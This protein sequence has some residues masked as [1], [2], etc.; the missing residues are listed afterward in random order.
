MGY[1]STFEKPSGTS[2]IAEKPSCERTDLLLGVPLHGVESEAPIA[3]NF[4][5]EHF[6]TPDEK[7]TLTNGVMHKELDYLDPAF[8]H[9]SGGTGRSFYYKLPNLSSVDSFSASFLYQH[10]VGIYLPYRF[11]IYLSENGND[12]KRVYQKRQFFNDVDPTIYRIEADFDASYCASWVRFDLDIHDHIWIESLSLYGCTDISSAAVITDDGSCNG[13][14]ARIVNRYPSY[15][16]LD[17]VHNILL[18]YNGMPPEFD[19]DGVGRF[20]VDDM[21][22]Y[23]AYIKDGKMQ[24]TFFDSVLFLPFAR[25]T[26]STLYKTADG[27]KYYLDNTFSEGENVDAVDKA[28]KIVS[29]ELGVEHNVKI[30][31]PIFHTKPT[32]GE[33]PDSFGDIDG[34]GIE[35]NLDDLKTCK[36]VTKW[37]IDAHIARFAEKE[38]KNVTLAGFYWHEESIQYN[39]PNEMEIL[40]YASE[41][42]H[43][44]GYRFIWIPYYQAWGYDNWKAN[45]FDIASIQPNYVFQK[46]AT[47]QRLYDNADI[48]KKFG[49]SYELEI[50]GV[51]DLES[52][53]RYKE[54]L[55]VG[56]EMGYMNTIKMYYQGGSDFLRAYRS[57]DKL[58]HSVYDDTYLFAKEKL[59]QPY[60]ENQDG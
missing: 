3:E 44:L 12:W 29:D 60:R 20:S 26:C 14:D 1:Y 50:N 56:V 52:I 54:Y 37:F 57:D 22:P 53:D 55:E 58:I 28:A 17:G 19:K 34:D 47:R 31:L 48:A 11:D 13:S 42:V 15:D 7:Y 35:E 18:A 39:R 23:L 41:Y 59:V 46:Q 9:F 43:S 25:Y 45:G 4:C 30:F 5:T 49:L 8:T 24:D 32:Y 10:S 16:E 6:N 38:R 27:W 40:L 21:L 51:E 2:P 36:K 33:F